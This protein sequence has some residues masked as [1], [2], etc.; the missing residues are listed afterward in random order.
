MQHCYAHVRN[1]TQNVV[2]LQRILLEGELWH[3]SGH[4]LNTTGVYG[5][6]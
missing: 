1:V 2:H 5:Q 6:D 4:L 3:M